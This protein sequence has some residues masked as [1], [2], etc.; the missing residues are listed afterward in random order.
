MPGGTSWVWT[1]QSPIIRIK[2]EFLLPYILMFCY[3]ILQYLAKTWSCNIADQ[4]I[5]KQLDFYTTTHF[6]LISLSSNSC[7]LQET[8][9]TDTNF[10]SSSHHKA[11][12]NFQI[13]KFNAY[14]EGKMCHW[15]VII[16]SYILICLFI[17]LTG[18]AT[19]CHY[20]GCKV[21]ITA[22]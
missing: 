10:A 16:K 8:T 21:K 5:Y 20:F 22:S 18:T 3:S 4:F 1:I 19:Q 13:I 12:A 9:E 6:Q 15:C 2:F 14:F 7:L 17:I 11:I